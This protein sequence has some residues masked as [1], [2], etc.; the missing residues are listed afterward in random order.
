MSVEKMAGAT[1][2]APKQ[3]AENIGEL[4]TIDVTIKMPKP[5]AQIF[6]PKMEAKYQPEVTNM[7]L[8]PAVLGSVSELKKIRK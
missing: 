8:V 1:K 3:N 5:E 2:S 6:T 4:Q 7:S